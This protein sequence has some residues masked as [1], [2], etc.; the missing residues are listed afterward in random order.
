MSLTPE[1]ILEQL[2]VEG[3]AI[4]PEM[5]LQ[6]KDVKRAMRDNRFCEHN[7]QW[8]VRLSKADLS[9][10]DPNLREFIEAKKFE[11]TIEAVTRRSQGLDK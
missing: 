4:L 11:A 1:Q 3:G 9:V 5:Y 6:P 7:K 2:L 10:I 8:Y